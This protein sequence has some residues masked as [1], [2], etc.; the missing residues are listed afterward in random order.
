MLFQSFF[1]LSPT[2]FLFFPPSLCVSLSLSRSLSLFLCLS[3]YFSHSLYL[4]SSISLC[5]SLSRSLSISL[6]LSFSLS[7]SFYFSPS[8]SLSLYFSS[9]SLCACP[10]S[11]L[12]FFPYLLV[13]NS[14]VSWSLLQD[15]ATLVHYAVLTASTQIVKILLLYDVNIDLPDNVCLRYLFLSS[16]SSNRLTS[17]PDLYLLFFRKAGPRS[18]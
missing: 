18:T 15:G 5:L 7:L 2:V 9:L 17:M 4:S 12:L 6:P 13:S 1:F 3:R 11:P 14:F 8:L 16:W 10:L